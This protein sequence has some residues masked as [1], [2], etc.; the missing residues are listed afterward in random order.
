MVQGGWR[1]LSAGFGA[2][3]LSAA[4]VVGTYVFQRA[5]LVR[6]LFDEGGALSLDWKKGTDSLGV[7][8]LPPEPAA[9]AQCCMQTFSCGFGRNP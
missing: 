6:P 1:S 5:V 4:S 8:S 2:H 9:R 3:S 7:S